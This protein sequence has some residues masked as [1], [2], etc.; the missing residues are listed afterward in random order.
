MRACFEA[1][2]ANNNMKECI[3]LPTTPEFQS[4]NVLGIL[5]D[6]LLSTKLRLRGGVHKAKASKAEVS[7]QS[8]LIR[9]YVLSPEAASSYRGLF[10]G[11]QGQN[12]CCP[13]KREPGEGI[14]PVIYRHH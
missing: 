6:E 1:D 5:S 8:L 11:L 3:F 9:Q 14:V 4:T 2:C 10:Q 12:C 7:E 13:R